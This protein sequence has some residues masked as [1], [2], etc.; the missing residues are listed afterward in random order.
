MKN[1][2]VL[3]FIGIGLVAVMVMCGGI[4]LVGWSVWY[5]VKERVSM[6][7]EEPFAVAD[8]AL[9]APAGEDIA[10]PPG[11][12]AMS[13][14]VKSEVSGFILPGAR[15]DLIGVMPDPD[16]AK[17]TQAMVVMQNVQVL[18]VNT[19]KSRPNPDGGVIENIML[20]TVAVAP[21]DT[22]KLVL[23]SQQGPLSVALRRPGE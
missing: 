10:V 5:R 6:Y 13:V 14:Q 1:P 7:P 22:P 23:A 17:K 15:V 12:R 8:V 16:D 11:M 18:A 21:E 2:T 20:I 4:G 9:K 3:I 19:A